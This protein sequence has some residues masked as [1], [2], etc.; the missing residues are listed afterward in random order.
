LALLAAILAALLPGNYRSLGAVFL[1]EDLALPL[2]AA[3]LCA[4]GAL[5]RA[6]TVGRG[7]LFGVSL[8]LVLASWHLMGMVVP[9]VRVR[10]RKSVRI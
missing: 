6:P 5:L 10:T 1:R 8:G 9:Q 7:A 2:Y 3:H 4:L